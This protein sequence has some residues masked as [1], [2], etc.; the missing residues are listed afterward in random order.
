M[1]SILKKLE[2]D[3]SGMDTYDY[4]VNHADSCINYMPQLSE[5]LIRVD[6]SGQF[7]ASA[8]RFL[9]AVDPESYEPYIGTFIE[10]AIDKDH[11]RKYIGGLLKAIWGEDFEENS[12]TL[13]ENDN[14]FRRIYKRL[15]PAK[16][17]N[18]SNH[19]I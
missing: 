16:A 17:L 12:I 3:D 8:A 9:H 11:E 19:L 2:K 10:A 14:N 6:N 13:Q 7:L 1:D 5:I 18:H 4:I 15:Y